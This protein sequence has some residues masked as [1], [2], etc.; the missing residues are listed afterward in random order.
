[1]ELMVVVLSLNR[2]PYTKRCLKALFDSRGAFDCVIVDNG[3]NY[4]VVD[5]LRSNWDGV[6]NDRGGS[7]R[8]VENGINLGVG[9]GMNVALKL[10]KSGQHVMKL[11]NDVEVPFK[12]CPKWMSKMRNILET[13]IGI[14]HIGF[15][16]YNKREI[17]KMRVVERVGKTSWK[18]SL[19][20]P[21]NGMIL[22]AAVMFR[23]SV[24]SSVGEFSEERLYGNIDTDYSRRCLMH[25]EGWYWMGPKAI[26]MDRGDLGKDSDLL[27]KIKEESSRKY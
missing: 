3:S 26:H 2:L 22:G 1:M 7:F 20:R 16:F 8:L 19:M 9:G 4:K 12:R 13:D 11:D 27:S 14:S 24:V 15:C 23:D 6:S 17:S 25:G 21:E 18:S 10:R 5:F